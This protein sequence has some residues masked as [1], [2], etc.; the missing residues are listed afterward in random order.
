MNEKQVIT[1]FKTDKPKA[2]EEIIEFFGNR[3]LR[4]AF[5][6]SKNEADA[7]DLV[8]DT[9][10][11]AIKSADKF[12]GD[13]GLYTWLYG[14]LFNLNRNFQRKNRPIYTDDIPEKSI[15]SNAAS[16]IDN[17]ISANILMDAIKK[18]PD[19][20]REIIILRYYEHMKIEA[21]AVRIGINKGTVKSRLHYAV[22]YLRKIIPKELNLF[23][24]DDT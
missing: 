3:L 18:L 21:I 8:Q 12:R 2:A 17:K 20:H 24:S 22:K 1:L 14:I 11:E 10:I 23:A 19:T 9:F 16:S 6:L 13:S 7:Q 15:P 5:V 4:S